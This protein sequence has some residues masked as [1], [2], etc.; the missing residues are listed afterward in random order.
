MK[1]YEEQI[2]RQISEKIKFFNLHRIYAAAYAG[3]LMVLMLVLPCISKIGVFVY[4]LIVLSFGFFL[5]T[6]LFVL[7]RRLTAVLFGLVFAAA[8]VFLFMNAIHLEAYLILCAVNAGTFWISQKITAGVML[9]LTKEAKLV[10]AL[11][12]EANTDS[13]TQLLNRNGIERALGTLWSFSKR[14]KHR[15]S[16]IMADVDYFK[17]YNDKFGHLEGDAI[18]KKVADCIRTSFR[19]GTDISGRI[20]GEEFLIVLFDTDDGQL[21]RMAHALLA[22]VT[23]LEIKTAKKARASAYLSLSIGIAS[24]VPQAHHT[25]TDFYKQAD[26]A[27]YQAKKSGRNCIFY[28]GEIF[29]NP[30]LRK[31]GGKTTF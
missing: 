5:S 22:A 30:G 7:S 16:F 24:G 10:C 1:E 8:C 18:L 12:T 6:I 27:L 31:A 15:I 29:R 4:I 14:E 21:I 26:Q 3:V 13:L 19:R 17:S 28:D 25:A 23:G 2:E 9:F 20:G 11:K